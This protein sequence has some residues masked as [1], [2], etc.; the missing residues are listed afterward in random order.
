MSAIECEIKP[1]HRV[2]RSLEA[3]DISPHCHEANQTMVPALRL[4]YGAGVV[5]M[6]ISPGPF[7][8]HTANG[9][10]AGI[11]ASLSEVL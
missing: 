7:G 5:V 9:R 6:L 2:D 1:L 11:E 4:P 8:L 3:P 10:P